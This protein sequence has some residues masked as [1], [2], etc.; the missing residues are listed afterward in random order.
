MSAVSILLNKTPRLKCSR[1]TGW[2]SSFRSSIIRFTISC[3]GSRQW[4]RCRSSRTH[5][6]TSVCSATPPLCRPPCP[7]IGNGTA[8]SMKARPICIHSDGG[9]SRMGGILKA[10]SGC[11]GPSGSMNGR[12]GS[13]ATAFILRGETSTPPC[14]SRCSRSMGW[15]SSTRTTS[16]ATSAAL[17]AACASKAAIGEICIS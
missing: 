4:R 9:F 16:A 14:R 11:G 17:Q 5:G 15:M 6:R 10:G 12:R 3:R 8:F 1:R 13:T 7:P 2:N